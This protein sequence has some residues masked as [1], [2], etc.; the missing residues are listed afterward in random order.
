MRQHK[1]TISSAF[2][3]L[4]STFTLSFVLNN[5]PKQVNTVYVISMVYTK[6]IRF[7]D[8]TSLNPTATPPRETPNI[9]EKTAAK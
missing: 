1:N 4:V 7:T 5:Q 2:S 3:K 8:I 6:N 9:P